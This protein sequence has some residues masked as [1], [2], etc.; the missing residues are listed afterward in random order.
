MKRTYHRTPSGS[1]EVGGRSVARTR[2]LRYGTRLVS[3]CLSDSPRIRVPVA[4]VDSSGC[5]SRSAMAG[6]P[7][8]KQSGGGVVRLRSEG[9]VT[10]S[11]GKHRKRNPAHKGDTFKKAEIK[12][13]R[14]TW[15]GGGGPRGEGTV[16]E[17]TYEQ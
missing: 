10:G 16:N 8:K 14:T 2:P 4:L 7:Y 3:V 5:F 1:P 11:I 12:M 6:G 17:D 13:V 9:P 15:P